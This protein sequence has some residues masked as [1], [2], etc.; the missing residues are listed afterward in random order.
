MKIWINTIHDTSTQENSNVTSRSN[1]V[2]PT[3]AKF[4]I[5]SVLLSEDCSLPAN[6]N[7]NPTNMASKQCQ[8]TSQS[9]LKITTEKL[10]KVCFII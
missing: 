10:K 2:V 6:K 5:T 3:Q 9:L 8:A 4:L 1:Y 7:T